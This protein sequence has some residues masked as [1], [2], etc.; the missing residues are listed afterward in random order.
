MVHAPRRGGFNR[1]AG[2][3]RGAALVEFALLLPFIAFLVFGTVD[4]GR[5]FSQQNRLKNASREG[6]AW[7]A[8]RPNRIDCSTGEPGIKQRVLDEDAGLASIP[9]FTV[10]VTVDGAPV[11]NSCATPVNPAIKVAPDKT[12]VVQVRGEF[13]VLTPFI[14]GVTGDPII[15]RA[16]TK[17]QVQQ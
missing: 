13:D 16:D 2:D 10:I 9:N 14:G 1:H 15:Q 17:I 3:E 8:M 6:A 11:T 5:G 12:V 4:L 7:A